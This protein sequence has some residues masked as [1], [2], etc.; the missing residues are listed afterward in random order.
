MI[1]PLLAVLGV[2]AARRS[3]M[4]GPLASRV[5]GLALTLLGFTAPRRRR[6]AAPAHPRAALE[7]LEHERA[8]A[9]RRSLMVWLTNL[10]VFAL[11]YWEFDRGGPDARDRR[12][13]TPEFIF[14]HMTVA[15]SS[16]GLVSDFFD[17][18]YL[19]FTTR[20]PSPDRHAAPRGWA[21][22]LMLAQSLSSFV[23]VVLGHGARRQ[24]SR[25]HEQSARSSPAPRRRC[26]DADAS[27]R[28]AGSSPWRRFPR[29]AR[30]R[31]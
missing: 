19:S 2:R 25:W 14:P 10:I 23:L 17:Y 12:A 22:L 30:S 13:A 15:R 24:H 8:P 20:P 11:W 7:Q 3:R 5:A 6:I 9:A 27:G 1:F 28:P 16:P 29:L 26:R 31:A 4:H 18:L 21:K